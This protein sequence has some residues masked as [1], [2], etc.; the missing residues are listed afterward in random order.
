MT[1]LRQS[2]RTRITSALL[3]AVTLFT[4]GAAN[5]QGISLGN[6]NSSSA[7]NAAALSPSVPNQT[8]PG[9][10]SAPQTTSRKRLSPEQV[11]EHLMK[12]TVWVFSGTNGQ[13]ETTG[14]GWVVDARQRLIITNQHVIMDPKNNDQPNNTIRVYFPV[15]QNGEYVKDKSH[16]LR[17]V[18]PSTGTVIA[19]SRKYELALV[20][21]DRMPAGVIAL[22]LA[23]KSARQAAQL[24]TMGGSPFGSELM[25]IY[26]SGRVRAI[27][28]RMHAMQRVTRMIESTLRINGG[29]S[30]GPVVDDYGYIVGVNEGKHRKAV[31]V[32]LQVDLKTLKTFLARALPLVN[33]QSSDA[34]VRRGDWHYQSNRHSQAMEDFSQAIVLNPKNAS[35]FAGRAKSLMIKGDRQTALSDCNRALQI[36]PS[37]HVAYYVRGLIYKSMKELDKARADLTSAI[38]YDMKNANYYNM[39]G[40]INSRSKKTSDAHRDYTRATELAPRV[41]TYWANRGYTARRLK[42]Y[43]QSASCFGNAF[44]LLPLTNYANEKGL[45]HFSDQDYTSAAKEFEKAC[46][47]HLN[48][49]KKKHPIYFGNLGQAHFNLKDYKKAY[50]A[51]SIAI[52]ANSRY[53]TAYYYRGKSLKALGHTDKANA[54]FAMAAKLDPKRYGSTTAGQTKRQASS[55]TQQFAGIWKCH[56]TFSN[57]AQFVCVTRL[58]KDGKFECV[59]KLTYPNGQSAQET[60]KGSFAADKT[61]VHFVGKDGKKI[62]LA[63][64]VENG[65]LKVYDY[66]AKMWLSYFRVKTN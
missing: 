14:T 3:L 19:S 66:E 40:F 56:T 42:S 15:K 46:S 54:D 47:L 27:G 37:S 39:R 38:S 51:F 64:K 20:Q 43:K 45:S 52:E 30:G 59:K 8:R 22:P 23:S 16:Y 63:W 6:G 5:G 36:A 11:A 53:A 50:A 31:N 2:M 4:T 29:N 12:G 7:A 28:N 62:S 10:I 24:H 25:W 32:S 26:S 57:G 49:E 58:T 35:A 44:T 34:Y 17:N 48:R 1:S 61:H 60:D 21:L 33:P 9:Q 13:M 55:I 65:G 41:A 18:K